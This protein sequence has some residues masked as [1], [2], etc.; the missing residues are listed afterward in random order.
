VNK[1]ET[2][3]SMGMR[4]KAKEQLI[5]ATVQAMNNWGQQL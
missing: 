3:A 4:V 5:R 2:A 1:K